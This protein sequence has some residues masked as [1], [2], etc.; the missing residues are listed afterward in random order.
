MMEDVMKQIQKDVAEN[1]VVLYM[2]GTPQCPQCAFSAVLVQILNNL[3]VPFKAVNVLANPAIRQLVKE[4]SNWPI[5]PQLY[6]CGEFVGGCDLIR[7][8]YHS[9]ELLTLFSERDIVRENSRVMG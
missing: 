1:R 6:I 7:E 5:I 8:M 4:F 9:G 3:E 2:K